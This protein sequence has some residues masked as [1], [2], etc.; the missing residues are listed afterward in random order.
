MAFTA[1]FHGTCAANC[2]NQVTPGDAATFVDDYLYH[3]DC[4]D[5]EPRPHTPQRREHPVCRRCYLIHPPQM[6]CRSW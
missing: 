5:T 2:G 6:E 1:R 3:A 4:V